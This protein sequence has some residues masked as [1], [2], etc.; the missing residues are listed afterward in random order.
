MCSKPIIYP[1]KRLILAGMAIGVVTCGSHGAILTNQMQKELPSFPLKVPEL[2]HTVKE[3]GNYFD[4]QGVPSDVKELQ[5]KV[6]AFRFV[7]AYPYSGS[8]TTDLYCFIKE[9]DAWVMFLKTFLWDTP[10]G[11]IVEFSV[12]GDFVDVIQGGQVVLK[13]N[14]YRKKQL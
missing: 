12:N 1:L 7:K 10:H 4:R 6:E 8:D 11:S 9:G 5:G 3:I 14:P 13:L 2:F